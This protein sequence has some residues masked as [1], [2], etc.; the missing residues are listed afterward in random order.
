MRPMGTNI[1]VV[2]WAISIHASYANDATS[3]FVRS[4]CFLVDFNPRIVRKRCDFTE[5]ELDIMY[6]ISIHASYANDA[7][8]LAGTWRRQFS[9]QCTHRTQTM[10]QI[11]IVIR[12]YGPV[13]SIHAS[14]ANDATDKYDAMCLLQEISIHASYA[15]DATRCLSAAWQWRTDF[16][17]RIVRKR[18]DGARNNDHV[19]SA[20]SIHA[21]YANDATSWQSMSLLVW[22]ISIHASYANDATITG[23]NAEPEEVFQST[24]RTQTMRPMIFAARLILDSISIHASY[25]NDATKRFDGL[26]ITED[27]SIHAS[28]AN[29]ATR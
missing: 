15:N 21:S 12:F 8:R 4:C 5:E 19:A 7:T 6:D 23:L 27:I 22:G 16:N 14:Y 3:S 9:F 20:I 11:Q 10:R 13:I 25:A 2:R 29:D 18:C 28:Y 1:K 24:H 26:V 17:P